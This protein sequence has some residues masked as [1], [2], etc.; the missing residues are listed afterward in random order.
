MSEQDVIVFLISA[1]QFRCAGVAAAH[2][3]MSDR[4][5][6]EHFTGLITAPAND[7][8][9][10]GEIYYATANFLMADSLQLL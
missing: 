5:G 3:P 10:E 6:G 7:I 1:D 4:G 2:Q 9:Y 8:K